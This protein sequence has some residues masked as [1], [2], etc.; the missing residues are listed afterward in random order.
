VLLYILDSP[1]ND[2]VVRF[3]V[4]GSTLLEG[5]VQAVKPVDAVRKLKGA[6]EEA[7]ET[8]KAV[9]EQITDG[10]EEMTRKPSDLEIEFGV[11]IDG[12]VGAVVATLSSGA[13]FSV[14]LRWTTSPNK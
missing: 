3:E 7:V 10:I 5:E 1:T 2:G 8:I 9:G 13:H 14:K 11:K 6:L 12:E 4:A